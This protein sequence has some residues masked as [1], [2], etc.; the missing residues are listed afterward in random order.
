MPGAAAPVGTVASRRLRI[1]RL[2][3]LVCWW[4]AWLPVASAQVDA[5]MPAP[6]DADAAFA[7]AVI[8]SAT[9]GGDR[10]T[11]GLLRAAADGAARF[12]VHYER[13]GASAASCTDV[14]LDHRRQLIDASARPLVPVVAAAEWAACGSAGSDPI[15]RLDRV[16]DTFFGAD[17]SLG[18]ARMPWLRQSALPRYRRYRENL[19]WQAGPVLFATLDVPDNNNDFRPG[20]GRNGEF[21][22]R[23]AA[24]RAWLERT[25]RVARERRLAGIV[26][27]IEAA[28]RFDAPLHAPDTRVRDRDGYY[29][30]K[31]ALRERM[32]AFPGQVLLV[33]SRR[34]KP[35][36]GA[37]VDHPLRDAAGR[38]F[39]RFS[40][41]AL[42]AD[43]RAS[44]WLRIA[45]DPG[46]PTLFDVTVERVFD[47]PSGELYGATDRR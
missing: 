18:R 10:P 23:V 1:A 14:A 19:R 43:D 24:N 44:Q 33:Q 7:F 13:A 47:D 26:L 22:E 27:F 38:P 3:G 4:A 8:G 35:E 21:D 39:E 45:V 2:A 31:L 9:D 42:P 36:T 5:D 46:R 40:R 32:A 20:A 30:L 37:P 6:V 12:V 11:L 34:V 28:P 41:V 25:F 29:E 16:G 15:E 17:Q